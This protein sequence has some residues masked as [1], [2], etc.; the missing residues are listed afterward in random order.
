MTDRPPRGG[1]SVEGDGSPRI[2][3][4]VVT[5]ERPE[6]LRTTL[7]A[8]ERQSRQL[9]RLVVVDNAPS[10]ESEAVVRDYAATRP[11]VE[12]LPSEANLGSVGGFGRGMERVLTFA[13]PDDWILSVDDD[14]PPYSDH[15]IEELTAFG[16]KLAADDPQLG[17]CGLVGSVFD[18]K[19]GISVRV[20]DEDLAGPIQVDWLG[21]NHFA[22]YRADAVRRTGPY[23]T[24]LFF[25]H[26]ELEYGLRMGKAGFHLYA[27]GD[28]W[29]ERRA[30]NDRLG[31]DLKPNRS[32]EAPTFRRYYRL[33]NLIWI[34]RSNGWH[35]TAA[36]VTLIRGFA[37]PLASAPFAPRLCLQH[38][39]LNTR[40]AVDG[41]RGRLGSRQQPEMRKEPKP[42]PP[43][44]AEL[45]ARRRR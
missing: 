20:P 3:G 38:L 32:L 29:R 1:E 36:K 39:R 28:L 12:Y 14:D 2:H 37:K 13:A 25:G 24:E 41:W 27:H 23:S 22:M 26:G 9:D 42:P 40:A 30:E 10:A 19:R 31:L 17:A 4:V 44:K 33:R 18:P 15:L 5:F 8:F 7:A 34:L 21:Q 35:R 11:G 43:T 45:E 16:A 6:I